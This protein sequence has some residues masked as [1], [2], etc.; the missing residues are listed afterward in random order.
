M[1]FVTIIA[2]LAILAMT[3]SAQNHC[4]VDGRKGIC[5]PTGYCR[6][7]G[8]SPT[9]NYCPNDPA[10]VQCCTYDGCTI[11]D[12][13]HRGGDCIPVSECTGSAFSNRCGGPSQIKCCVTSGPYGHP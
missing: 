2:S 9:P 4:S 13:N 10:D 5:V 7:G 8:G 1:R 12:T 11:S 3:A 6:N